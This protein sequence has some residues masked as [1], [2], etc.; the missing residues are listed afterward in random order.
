MII[1]YFIFYLKNHNDS[2]ITKLFWIYM[3]G[4]LEKKKLKKF[5]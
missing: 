1:K 5:S 4:F 2:Y 3:N